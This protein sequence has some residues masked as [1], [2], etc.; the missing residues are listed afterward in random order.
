ME[1]IGNN[2]LFGRRKIGFLAGSKIAPLSVLPTLD[3][4]SEIATREDVAVVSGFHSQLERQVL[5]LLLKGKCGIICVLAR[6]LYSKVPT[7]Y[8][9][10]FDCGR[11]LFITEEKQSRATKESSHRRNKLIVFLSDELVTPDISPNSSLY[12]ILS[13]FNNSI[14]TL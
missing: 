8:K 3:W 7:E 12:A 6:S 14:L 9:S 4:A 11:V 1:S 2:S 13:S 5:A 10:A